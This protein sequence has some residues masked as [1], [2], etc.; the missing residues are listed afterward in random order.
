[1]MG[2][3]LLKDPYS[4]PVIQVEKSEISL[5]TY[6]ESLAFLL[7]DLDAI[8]AKDPSIL[9]ATKNN[10]TSKL[11][12]EILLEQY[13]QKNG[14]FVDSSEL[15]ARIKLIKDEY[16]DD[17][18]FLTE[19]KEQDLNLDSWK[20]M[21]SRSL[22]LEKSKQKIMSSLDR[23][24]LVTESAI[25]NEFESRPKREKKERYYLSQ[26]VVAE[27]THAE[28]IKSNL[29]SKKFSE[30]ARKH[31]I[32]PESKNGGVVGWVEIGDFPVFDEAI[33]LPLNKVT[34]PLRSDFGFHLILIEKK[35]SGG[36]MS[37]KEQRSEIIADLVARAE[38]GVF[39]NWLDQSL[40]SHKI[41][42]NEDAI[43]SLFVGIEGVKK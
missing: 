17:L 23:S 38:Q 12:M 6:A 36:T 18:S 8:Q 13:A 22:L 26:I 29:K 3:G 2:C 25:K 30:L 16:P 42:V 34:P 5:K 10:L 39:T 19:L 11:I 31:S 33:K 21:I 1:M 28:E 40:K 15:N 4:L 9:K 37:L 14:V 32:A 27:L 35:A 20:K 7:K 24:T 43:G 41:L